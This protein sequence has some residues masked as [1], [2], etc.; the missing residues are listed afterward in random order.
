MTGSE[1]VHTYCAISFYK[2]HNCQGGVVWFLD[3]ILFVIKVQGPRRCIT[4]SHGKIQPRAEDTKLPA[5]LMHHAQQKVPPL[6]PQSSYC[7]HEARAWLTLSTQEVAASIARDWHKHR[8]SNSSTATI[9]S[10]MVVLQ[11]IKVKL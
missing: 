3:Q 5:L 10:L 11:R 9:V 4:P 8:K 2:E 6:N 7:F 1:S